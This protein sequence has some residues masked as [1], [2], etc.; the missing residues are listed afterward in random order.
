MER[1]H[2]EKSLYFVN[3]MITVLGR[4]G[5]SRDEDRVLNVIGCRYIEEE[6]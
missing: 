3:V 5:S 6:E 1:E 4:Y 2:A